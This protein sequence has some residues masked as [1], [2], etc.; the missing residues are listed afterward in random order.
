[1]NYGPREKLL[2]EGINYLSDQ[3]LLAI[4]LNTGTK[5]QNV[6]ELSN[7]VLE[8]IS[9][10]SII[11]T[12]D[13]ED[14]LKIKGIGYAKASRIVASFELYKRIINRSISTNQISSPQSIYNA[15][16]GNFK[17]LIIEKAYALFL[18]NK[19]NIL[20]IKEVGRGISN[21]LLIDENELI[22]KAIVLN[23]RFVALIHNHPYGSLKPSNEDLIT[24][25]DIENKLALFNVILFDHLIYTDEGY[26]SIKY[27][28]KKILKNSS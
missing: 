14:L 20:S 16:S 15:I 23:A 26:Y 3:E 4:L 7:I 25:K 28:I 13:M 9:N 21:K 22:R 5:N 11:S 19:K 12:L 2:K 17:G 24:T 18:D 10:I 1:M 8:E 6:L 27:G